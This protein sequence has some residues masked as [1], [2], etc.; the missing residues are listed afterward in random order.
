MLSG[1]ESGV[2][3]RT[4]GTVCDLYHSRRRKL[5]LSVKG[6]NKMD[7]AFPAGNENEVGDVDDVCCNPLGFG[8]H[9][10]W[11]EKYDQRKLAPTNYKAPGWT[12]ISTH[13]SILCANSDASRSKGWRDGGTVTAAAN[14][15][16]AAGIGKGSAGQSFIRQATV[17]HLS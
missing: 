9:H 17:Y 6:T 4:L 7:M 10:V 11:F 1:P 14:S 12:G 13:P 8:M 15:S 3:R 5:S 2:P 16:V